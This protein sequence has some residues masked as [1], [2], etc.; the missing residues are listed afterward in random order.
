MVFLVN[1][2]YFLVSFWRIL[3]VLILS[4]GDLRSFIFLLS[5]RRSRDLE[6]TVFID[7]WCCM[8]GIVR[9]T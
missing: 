2:M 5:H 9:Y 3:V 4:R 1:P 8:C 7:D 6:C